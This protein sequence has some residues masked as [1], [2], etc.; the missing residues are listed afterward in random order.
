MTTPEQLDILETWRAIPAHP[1][2]LVS[3]RGRILS[4]HGTGRILKPAPNSK[5]YLKVCLGRAHQFYVHQLVMLAFHGPPPA[6]H[7]IDHYDFD[8]TNNH[9]SNLRYLPKLIN[10]RRWQNHQ[11]N[12][13]PTEIAAIDAYYADLVAAGV[14]EG[15]A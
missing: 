10:D 1:R 2:Y 8:R 4:D 7:N 9:R 15:A 12:L 6:G 11:D 3:D 13:D 14:Y 5:G